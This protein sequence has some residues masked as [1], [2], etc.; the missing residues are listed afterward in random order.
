M[1]SAPSRPRT[2]CRRSCGADLRVILVGDDATLRGVLEQK[3][4]ALALGLLPTYESWS[5]P[6]VT[7]WG[8]GEGDRG[9][10]GGG[11]PAQQPSPSVGLQFTHLY[12]GV[13]AVAGRLGDLSAVTARVW[14]TFPKPAP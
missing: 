11:H 10:A 13:G 5:K 8:A 1:P 12:H 7:P 14:G 9:C 4:A 3:N 2:A 6:I